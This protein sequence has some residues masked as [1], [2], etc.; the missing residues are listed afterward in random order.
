[1]LDPTPTVVIAGKSYTLRYTLS[2]RQEIEEATGKNPFAAM[3]SGLLGDQVAILW[4]G[5][6]HAHKTLTRGA[7][8]ELLEK[9]I[10]GGDFYDPIMRAAFGAMVA[11]RV[12]GKVNLAEVERVWKLTDDDDEGK[13]P[14]G[15]AA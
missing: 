10:E 6:K 9:H 2:A 7:V 14:G 8:Q 11:S 3:K 1:M 13:A 15:A 4:A 12:C 5:M